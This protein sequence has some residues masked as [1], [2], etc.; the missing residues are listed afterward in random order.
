MTLVQMPNSGEMKPEETTSGRQT[1][2]QVEKQVHQTTF[3]YFNPE[4]FLREI[5]DN[6]EA[7]IVDKAIQ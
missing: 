7:E 2:P 6:N 4:L 5:K 3:K 1:G